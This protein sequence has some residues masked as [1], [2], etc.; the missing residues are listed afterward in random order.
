MPHQVGFVGHVADV[1]RVQQEGE[2]PVCQMQPPLV[3]E[4]APHMGKGCVVP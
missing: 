1:D 4:P 3:L 2:D